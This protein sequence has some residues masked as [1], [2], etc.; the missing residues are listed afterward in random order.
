MSV[1]TPPRPPELGDPATRRPGGADRGGAS[2]TPVAGVS[3]IWSGVLAAMLGALWLYSLL[4]GSGR[5]AAPRSVRVVVPGATS[6]EGARCRRSSPTTRTAASYSSDAT[7]RAAFSR[8]AT[9]GTCRAAGGSSSVQRDRV[10][11]RRLEAPRSALGLAAR[12]RRHRR[13]GHGRSDDR[14][15]ARWSL[16]ARRHPDRVRSSRA[17]TRP[18]ALPRSERRT[19]PNPHRR[20]R[21]GVLVVPG[22]DEARVHAEQVPAGIVIAGCQRSCVPRPV[23]IAACGGR[24]SALGAERAMV[25]RRVAHRL[26]GQAAESS[27]FARTARRSA[28]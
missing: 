8:Q 20:A 19:R 26:R 21:L 15:G 17:R 12:A 9:F 4:G 14:S 16:V 24:T 1:I 10:V 6:S 7:G 25:S 18:S 3:A 2:A 5:R 28:G 23:A 27:S 22:R 13:E 11:A